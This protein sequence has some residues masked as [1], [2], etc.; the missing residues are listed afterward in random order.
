M[1]FHSAVPFAEQK[2]SVCVV[3]LVWFCFCGLC[4]CCQT[5]EI[6]SPLRA[7]LHLVCATQCVAGAALMLT[8]LGLTPKLQLAIL[9]V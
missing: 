7:H 8:S 6:V 4:L 1:P 5:H 2:L 9:V 3:P